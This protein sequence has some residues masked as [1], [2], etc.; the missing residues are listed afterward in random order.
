LAGEGAAAL[1]AASIVFKSAN[2]SYSST[3]LTH[4]KSLYK[5]A[6]AHRDTYTTEITDATNFYKSWSG[7]GDELAWSAA[8][9]WRATNDSTYKTAVEKHFKEFSKQ[10]EDR[11]QQFTWDDK[12]AGVQTLMAK[13]TGDTKYKTLATNYCDWLISTAPK[14][15]KGLIYLDQWGSLRHAA[16]VSFICLEAATADTSKA[17]SYKAFAEKQIGYILGDTGRSYVV[18]Y[19]TNPPTRPHHRAASCPD[20]PAACGFTYQD[21]SGPNPHVLTGALVG[22]PDQSDAYTDSRTDYVHNE[23]ADD[24]NAGFQSALAALLHLG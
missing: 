22:G 15:P 7:Y 17:A 19:G 24:Y 8:W 5:F 3:L 6:D 18:G 20:P 4:A 21:A 13:L 9:L 10:L 11:P 14:T 16:G 23:V 2:S 1:A 12:T